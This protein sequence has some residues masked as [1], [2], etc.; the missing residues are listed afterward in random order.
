MYTRLTSLNV[1]FSFTTNFG[2]TSQ[3]FNRYMSGDPPE[4][5]SKLNK[6]KVQL[7]VDK[8][9][10]ALTAEK[11]KPIYNDLF[12][13]SKVIRF[14]KFAA[15][16]H[17]L[18][19]AYLHSE[20]YNL[21]SVCNLFVN[22]DDKVI[23]FQG[24][25]LNC[26]HI[27]VSPQTVV[28]GRVKADKL[29]VH[30]DEVVLQ[31]YFGKTEFIWN[32][33]RLKT[34][35]RFKETSCDFSNENQLSN[36]N[37]VKKLNQDKWCIIN[38]TTQLPFMYLVQPLGY[39]M[40]RETKRGVQFGVYVHLTLLPG[41]NQRRMFSKNEKL[42]LDSGNQDSIV[43]N[44]LGK[45]GSSS[46]GKKV[47]STPM[48]LHPFLI[49]KRFPKVSQEDI[50][51]V[52]PLCLESPLLDALVRAKTDASSQ[53]S[54]TSIDNTFVCGKLSSGDMTNII[55][56][57]SNKSS[58]DDVFSNMPSK[59]AIDSM[60]ESVYAALLFI[61]FKEYMY[62]RFDGFESFECYAKLAVYLLHLVKK[63]LP[64]L[65]LSHQHLANGNILFFCRLFFRF[66]C[67]E[68]GIMIPEGNGRNFSSVMVHTRTKLINNVFTER[69]AASVANT[70]EAP[71]FSYLHRTIPCDYIV[72]K[73][74]ESK[75]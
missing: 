29:R 49:E 45:G 41:V 12:D 44:M 5:A 1:P 67:P 56:R 59:S 54:K 46:E 55:L 18:Q 32:S 72:P 62:S 22:V 42:G 26:M 68:L 8:G 10:H 20:S 52:Q 34:V 48:M 63:K 38:D 15:L 69:V 36:W 70:F 58:L 31:D 11:L 3:L 30:E 28:S 37:D 75:R 27:L 64:L 35:D 25:G 65:T 53:S 51:E 2:L 57:I 4:F 74:E 50:D 6:M 33:A 14:G 40:Y 16:L 71:Q 13:T 17:F 47:D 19:E 7:R 24:S 61:N 66:L 23:F 39:E 21:I 60:G 73:V 43:L 9:Y